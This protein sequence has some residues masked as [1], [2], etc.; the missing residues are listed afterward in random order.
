MNYLFVFAIPS[1]RINLGKRENGRV[2]AWI[3]SLV[4]QM[5]QGIIA[6]ARREDLAEEKKGKRKDGMT[7]WRDVKTEIPPWLAC[8]YLSSKPIKSVYFVFWLILLPTVHLFAR[9]FLNI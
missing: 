3:E 7:G 8:F 4:T 6:A 1:A 2:A 5:K 9:F